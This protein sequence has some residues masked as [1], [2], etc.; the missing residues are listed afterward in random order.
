MRIDPPGLTPWRA[1]VMPRN[2]ARRGRQ[3]H[4]TAGAGMRRSASPGPPAG[5]DLVDLELRGARAHQPPAY[6]SAEPSPCRAACS[7][8]SSSLDSEVFS[9]VPPYLL[10]VSTALSGVT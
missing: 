4:A 9:T 10:I 2:E 7:S 3:G 6:Y 5:G 8:A 1:I